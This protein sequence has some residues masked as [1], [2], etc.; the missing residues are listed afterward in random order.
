MNFHNPLLIHRDMYSFF[1]CHFPADKSV[2]F[3]FLMQSL[4]AARMPE[5]YA[6][7]I[8]NVIINIIHP[9]TILRNCYPIKK[10][11]MAVHPADNKIK[12]YLLNICGRYILKLIYDFTFFFLSRRTGVSS[13]RRP[14]LL[15][16]FLLT[17]LVFYFHCSSRIISPISPV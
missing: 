16:L 12:I 15:F 2:P 6:S 13:V 5:K 14:V 17:S 9:L 11:R 7:Q 8:I 1:C 10:S 4:H 3:T